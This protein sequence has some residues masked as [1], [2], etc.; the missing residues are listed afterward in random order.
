MRSSSILQHVQNPLF[1]ITGISA[2]F[3]IGFASRKCQ[4][5]SHVGRK[6]TSSKQFLFLCWLSCNRPLV[7][8]LIKWKIS[9]N[10]IVNETSS[11]IFTV[12]LWSSYTSADAPT[13]N[14]YW[15]KRQLLLPLVGA[16]LIEYVCAH[17]YKTAIS[18][19]HEHSV[20]SSNTTMSRALAASAPVSVG[21]CEDST[22]MSTLQ[23]INE[24]RQQEH[25][26]DIEI[27]VSDA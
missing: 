27:E 5:G 4:P 26:I 17:W 7:I 15:L 10:V 9:Q 2:H 25:F 13:L 22:A 21:N 8:C 11:K 20:S 14:V 6:A 18:H 23:T 16:F 3:K 1:P 12:K 24:L 19:R